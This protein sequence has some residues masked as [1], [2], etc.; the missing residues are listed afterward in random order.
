MDDQEFY[1]D[2]CYYSVK[3]YFRNRHLNS[4]I[5]RIRKDEKDITNYKYNN[6]HKYTIQAIL[7]EK[8]DEKQT[9]INLYM[10]AGYGEDEAKLLYAKFGKE[11]IC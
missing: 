1:C 3:S 11:F 9:Y 8:E 2:C 10:D 6:Q 5:H 7:K 4:K